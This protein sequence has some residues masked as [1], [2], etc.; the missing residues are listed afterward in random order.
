VLLFPTSPCSFGGI[1]EQAGI[2]SEKVN[3]SSEKPKV[4]RVLTYHGFFGTVRYSKGW[5]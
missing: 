3:M 5:S 2:I 4:N 1:Y